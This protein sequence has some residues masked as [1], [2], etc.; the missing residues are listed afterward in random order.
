MDILTAYMQRS[1]PLVAVETYEEDRFIA[2]LLADCSKLVFSCAAVGGLRALSRGQDGQTVATV[3]DDKSAPS[4]AIGWLEGQS[5]TV[6]LLHDLRGVV[7]NPGVYRAL[8]LAAPNYKR[9]GCMVVLLGPV[10]SLPEELIR[11]IPVEQFGL[12]TR[13]QLGSA[14]LRVISDFTLEAAKRDK[15]MPPVSEELQV[16]LLDE[17]AGLTLQEAETLFAM[18]FRKG[19]FDP[20]I[21]RRGKQKLLK[22]QGG[23]TDM[24]PVDPSNVGGLKK[25]IRHLTHEVL[26]SW[27]NEQLRTKGML[28]L[29][30]P[31]TGKTLVGKIVAHVLG[32]PAYKV[33]IGE[34]MGSL[35]GQS[36]GQLR[37]LLDT[38]DAMAPCVVFMDE[39]EKGLGGH[40]SSAKS[41]GG[42]LLRMV[43]KLLNWMQEHTSAVMIVATCNR[44]DLLPEELLRTG[45]FDTRWHVGH[46]SLGERVGIAKIHLARFGAPE[47]LA[48]FIAENTDAYTGAEIEGAIK[49]AARR[50]LQVPYS[51]GMVLECIRDIQPVSRS[52]AD[53]IAALREYAKTNLLEASDEAPAADAPT[54]STRALDVDWN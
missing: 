2:E 18:A 44:I 19:T 43:G 14:L 1:V 41:D 21:V 42:T 12:P 30:P 17:A 25:L 3:V 53:K 50:A 9:R 11:Q 51:E 49:S 5:S 47:S 52:M 48:Q 28:L 54:G 38:L 40:Q 46:P 29:G 27:H 32:C 23:M 7:A 36:E 6:L 16:R 35:V 45:R 37:R 33:D 10:I 8:L 31:G 39:I 20:M 15:V 4:K 26:P 34:L 24:P 22:Q 13:E